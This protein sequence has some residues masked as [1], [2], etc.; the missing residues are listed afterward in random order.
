MATYYMY[1]RARKRIEGIVG[2]W[3]TTC[4]NV[5]TFG[6]LYEIVPNDG[7]QSVVLKVLQEWQFDGHPP[8]KTLVQLDPPELPPQGHTLHRNP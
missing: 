1:I 4:E 8:S 7:R 5:Y 6:M 3:L 2:M